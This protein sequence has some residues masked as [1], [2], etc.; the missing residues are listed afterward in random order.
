MGMFLRLFVQSS[1]RAKEQ[2]HPKIE[3]ECSL[4]VFRFLAFFSFQ[5]FTKYKPKRCWAQ[6]FAIVLKANNTVIIDQTLLVL[7]LTNIK[8]KNNFPLLVHNF[9]ANLT[10]KFG[11]RISCTAFFSGLIIDWH[12]M[13]VVIGDGVLNVSGV[14]NNPN[15]DRRKNPKSR[16]HISDKNKAWNPIWEVL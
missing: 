11:V 14:T 8:Q 5:K 4:R 9:V 3:K 12:L 1:K 7:S 2:K 10:F 15:S 16:S 6:F 13:I